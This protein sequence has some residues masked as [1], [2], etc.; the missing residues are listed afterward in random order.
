VKSGHGNRD[1]KEQFDERDYAFTER[2][3]ECLA[4]LGQLLNRPGFGA[5]PATIGAE[6]ELFLIDRAAR[7]LAGHL[8]F[9]APEPD[10]RR[11]GRL[12]GGLFSRREPAAGIRRG[13]I[14]VISAAH[15]GMT[16][17]SA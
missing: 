13:A 11:R 3:T 12:P 16:M 17:R 10:L 6:L 4:A 2:L 9:E 8:G 14:A 1:G 7:P 5:G 15:R